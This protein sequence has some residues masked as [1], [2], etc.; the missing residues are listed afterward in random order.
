MIRY[1]SSEEEPFFLY[2]A[3][4]HMHVPLAHAPKYDNI[5]GRG[6]YADTLRE[7]DALVGRIRSAVDQRKLNDTLI[8][9]LSKYF[10]LIFF[11]FSLNAVKYN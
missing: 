7:M 4:S 9:F 3:L 2:A 8:W 1:S 11:T 6:M 10:F 5:T